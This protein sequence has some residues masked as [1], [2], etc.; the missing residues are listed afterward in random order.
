ME[1]RFTHNLS[2]FNTIT[3]QGVLNVNSF[4]PSKSTISY[5]DAVHQKGWKDIP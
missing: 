5:Q 3:A 1:K 2:I 4:D